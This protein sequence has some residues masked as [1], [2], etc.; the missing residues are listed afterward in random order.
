MG[1]GRSWVHIVLALWRLLLTICY[2]T[3]YVLTT[4]YYA[5]LTYTCKDQVVRAYGILL[6]KLL[7]LRTAYYLLLTDKV[8]IV[9]ALWRRRS[10]RAHQAHYLLPTTYYPLLTTYYLLLT[11]YYLQPASSPGLVL[12]TTDYN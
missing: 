5:M 8:H 6:T 2:T 7:T 4:T 10:Q 3:Y 1:D 9:L 12:T 11:T